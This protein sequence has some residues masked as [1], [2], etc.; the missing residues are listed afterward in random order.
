MHPMVARSKTFR[1]PFRRSR[2]NIADLIH[3]TASHACMMASARQS[4]PAWLVAFGYAV[5][6]RRSRQV[7]SINSTAANPASTPSCG[8][9]PVIAAP[10]ATSWANASFAHA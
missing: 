5:S 9:I 7:A 10:L 4:C 2:L 8:R 1:T 3:M 6:T